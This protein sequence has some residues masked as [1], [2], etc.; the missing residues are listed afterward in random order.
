MTRIAEKIV[1]DNVLLEE[2]FEPGFVAR[3][4]KEFDGEVMIA[5][6]FLISRPA[7]PVVI[8]HENQKD[9]ETRRVHINS[10]DEQSLDKVSRVLE[11]VG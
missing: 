9:I 7:T 1:L 2:L 5:G 11:K 4:R 6:I 3:L 8:S 10:P